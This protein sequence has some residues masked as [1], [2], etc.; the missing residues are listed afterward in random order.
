[1]EAYPMFD[2]FKSR[3]AAARENDQLFGSSD[4]LVGEIR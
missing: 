1:M 3:V 2:S 4:A